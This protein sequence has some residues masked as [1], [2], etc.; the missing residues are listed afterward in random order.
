MISR[1]GSARQAVPASACQV[2]RGHPRRRPGVRDLPEGALAP[3]LVE[4]PLRAAEQRDPASHRR[5]WDLPGP[6]LTDPPGRCRARRTARRVGRRSPLPRPR[7]PRPGP[8]HRRPRHHQP[9]RGGDLRRHD[10]GAQRLTD[11]QKIT[12]QPSHTT[13]RDLTEP[14]H[15]RW[16]GSALAD[17]RCRSRHHRR[18]RYQLV[19]SLQEIRSAAM[20]SEAPARLARPLPVAL[21]GLAPRRLVSWS[22]PPTGVA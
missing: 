8:D 21:R 16:L 1:P 13:P 5:G 12:R 7:C 18:P 2:V 19:G 10:P 22:A 11:I 9:C 6:R 3:D 14:G 4:Q 20:I 15:R 17:E